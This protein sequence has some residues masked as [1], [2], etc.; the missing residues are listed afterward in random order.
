[1]AVYW[2]TFYAESDIF[3]HL[4]EHNDPA[5]LLQD[6]HQCYTVCAGFSCFSYF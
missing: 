2:D 3:V 1:M 6:S 4:S 5:A